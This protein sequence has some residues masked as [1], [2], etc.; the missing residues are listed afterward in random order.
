MSR[1]I[2]SDSLP[3]HESVVPA[4]VASGSNA[5]ASPLKNVSAVFDPK[6]AEPV[7]Q[8]N[9]Q[10]NWPELEAAADND[11]KMKELLSM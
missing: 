1:Q 9:L 11:A 7:V 10:H 6:D 4:A 3:V 2:S 5:P 8:G